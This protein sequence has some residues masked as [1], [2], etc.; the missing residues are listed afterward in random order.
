VEK[1]VRNQEQAAYGVKQFVARIKNARGQRFNVFTTG[2]DKYYF[3][4]PIDRF[5]CSYCM[6]FPVLKK[7]LRDDIRRALRHGW[8]NTG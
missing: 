5:D 7:N 3:F 1:T 8:G 6:G 2:D 4:D